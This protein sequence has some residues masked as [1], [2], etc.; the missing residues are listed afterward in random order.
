MKKC[1]LEKPIDD[2][3]NDD[4]LGVNLHHTPAL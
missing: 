4:V 1:S 3:V 2:D